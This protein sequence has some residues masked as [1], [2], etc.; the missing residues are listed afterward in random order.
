[1]QRFVSRIELP[2][3]LLFFVLAALPGLLLRLMFLTPLALNYKFILHGH[4]HI[5]MLGWVYFA[6][7][8]LLK[9]YLIPESSLRKA[10]QYNFILTTITVFG[11]MFSFPFTGYAAVSIASSS[12]FI[13]ASY[14]FSYIFIKDLKASN[15]S[16]GV[17]NFARAGIFFLVLSSFGPWGLAGIMTSGNSGST[18]YTNAIYYYLH[19]MYN[20]F[21]VFTLIALMVHFLK[22]YF[23]KEAELKRA[24][25]II[26]ISGIATLLLS[27][28]WSIENQIFHAVGLLTALIQLYGFYLLYSALK[29]PWSALKKHTAIGKTLIWTVLISLII[30][31]VLQI[32]SSCPWI[33]GSAVL[34]REFI[35]GYLHL[36]FLGLISSIL[37]FLLFKSCWKSALFNWAT[38]IF[39]L[40]LVGSE[41]ALYTNG[42]L[43][44]FIIHNAGLFAA[45][46]FAFSALILIAA[47]M[48]FMLSMR[49]RNT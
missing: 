32:L 36:V 48:L 39:V 45:L 21:M 34:I 41:L 17:K 3:S 30:K 38:G 23:Q 24:F 6:M 25:V 27:F 42:V 4:S 10:Y 40:G 2:L 19:F 44:L 18:L 26:F 20:G 5:A 47:L 13:I 14:H 43:Q 12:L 46:V 28:L 22:D 11:M 49:K 31:L 16:L 8:L 29:S 35:I 15:H 1:M 37:I 9:K 7:V 33:V